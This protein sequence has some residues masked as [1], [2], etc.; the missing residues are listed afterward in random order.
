[1]TVRVGEVEESPGRE[2]SAK[3]GTGKV[4]VGVGEGV[5]EGV[6]VGERKRVRLGQDEVEEVELTTGN[7]PEG[8]WLRS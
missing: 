3:T 7:D 4:S 2:G 5:V 6:E 1:V 8:F